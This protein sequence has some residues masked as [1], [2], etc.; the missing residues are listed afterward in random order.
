MRKIAV[1]GEKDL[2]E[3]KRLVRKLWK[4]TADEEFPNEEEFV[5]QLLYL[6]DG[7]WIRVVRIDNKMHEGKS[8]VHIHILKRDK[9]LWQEMSF[10][11]ADKRIIEIGEGVIRNIINRI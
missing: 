4:V 8:G 1:D 5:L 6:K 2:G 9:V 7:K 10:E 11:E 3:N